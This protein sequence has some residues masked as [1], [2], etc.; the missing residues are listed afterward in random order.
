MGP[1]KDLRAPVQAWIRDGLLPRPN[2]EAFAAG[3][4]AAA[5]G[6]GLVAWLDDALP[7]EDGAWPE[8]LRARVRQAHRLAAFDGTQRLDLAARAQALLEAAGV[9]VLAL[10]G[11]AL[12]ETVAASP[13]HRPMVDVDL[14]ALD[15]PEEAQHAL[16]RA[17]FRVFERADHAS[18]LLDPVSGGRL[19]LHHSV[20]SCPGLFPLDAEALWRDRVRTPSGIVVPSREDLIV[21]LALHAS[22]QHGLVLSLVQYL[23]FRLLLGQP[24]N[25]GRVL[26]KAR[27]AGAEA[28]LALALDAARAVCGA[29]A[30]PGLV[31]GLGPLPPNSWLSKRLRSPVSLLTP[32][33]APL[34][35]LRWRV[36]GGRHLALLRHTL[37][38]APV[39]GRSAWTLAGRRIGRLLRIA[40][41]LLPAGGW[42]VPPE[43]R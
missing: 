26:E 36:T 25:V 29:E 1:S 12:V 27:S 30:P 4:A 40:R 28:A 11:A 7:A 9:R 13:A 24:L 35:A 23:D 18:C 31:E 3:F 8:A 20:T 6:Q 33:R 37:V 19:E 2:G 21:Q 34:A 38:G 32:A 42:G 39:P 10:K 17:G 43:E 16:L 41:R 22:F 5:A 14:L 15:Y